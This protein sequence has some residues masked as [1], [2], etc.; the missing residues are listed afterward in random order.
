MKSVFL[1]ILLALCATLLPGCHRTPDEAQVRDA[2]ASM[3]H[4][5]EAGSAGDASTPLSDDFDGNAGELDR[6]ALA[7][8]I[9]LTTLHDEHIG[10][11]M[12]P[13]AI[14]RRGERIVASFTVTLTRGGTLPDQ[15]GVYRVESAWRKDG[16]RWLCYT[17]SWKQSI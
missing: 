4:A 8:M 13:I 17:A 1:L 10:V 14:E 9:R 12:G 2:M 16:R 5:V 6:R 15:L 11:T 3:A 7:N